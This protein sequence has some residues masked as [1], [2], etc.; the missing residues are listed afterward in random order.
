MEFPGTEAGRGQGS[1]G[2]GRRLGRPRAPHRLRVR[3]KGTVLERSNHGP[4]MLAVPRTQG[5]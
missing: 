2:C 4:H 5:P 3:E 1:S